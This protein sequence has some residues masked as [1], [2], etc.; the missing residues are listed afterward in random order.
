MKYHRRQ[1]YLDLLLDQLE[2]PLLFRGCCHPSVFFVANQR[3][4]FLFPAVFS[5]FAPR[6]T[7]SVQFAPLVAN[8]FALVLLGNMFLF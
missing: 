3:C 2:Q 1:H 4:F 7:R 6:Q 8:L 5:S